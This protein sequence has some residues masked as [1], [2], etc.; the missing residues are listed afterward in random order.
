MSVPS[1]FAG[2][3]AALGVLAF[4]TWRTPLPYVVGARS[5]APPPSRARGSR[6]A[7]PT[8]AAELPLL[9]DLLATAT[10]AGMSGTVAFDAAA[11]ALR[12]PLGVS[13]RAV[14]AATS[15]GG[16]LA[17][18]IRATAEAL[19]LPDLARAASILERSG[20]LGVPVSVALREL[21]AE[22]RRTHRREAEQRARTAPVRMLFPLVFLVLPAF[23]LLTVVPMLL[24][25]LGSL[26]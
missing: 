25:T 9:L 19:G 4:A 24:A 8:T 3:A 10:G 7:G 17:D 14:T 6:S 13:L 15:L 11:T 20:S 23:L 5:V 12:G 21:A 1:V 22:H 26:S 18:G 2:F 16:Q